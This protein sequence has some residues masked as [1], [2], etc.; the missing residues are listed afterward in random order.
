MAAQRNIII[1]INI[2]VPDSLATAFTGGGVI[3][4]AVRA[5]DLPVPFRVIVV[6]NKASAA[7]TV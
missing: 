1:T 7:L 2:L 3:L 6:I 5:N 4:Q